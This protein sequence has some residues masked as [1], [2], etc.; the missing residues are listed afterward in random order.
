[1]KCMIVKLGADLKSAD[2]YIDI[3]SDRFDE[4]NKNHLFFLRLYT[5]IHYDEQGR[6]QDYSK[7]QS[8]DR[9]LGIS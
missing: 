3:T 2:M 6:E 7:W 5:N 8:I 1:M 4:L 9:D